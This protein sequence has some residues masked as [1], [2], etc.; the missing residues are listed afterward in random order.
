MCTYLVQVDIADLIIM[1][2]IMLLTSSHHAA[3]IILCVIMLL[4]LA[5]GFRSDV[6]PLDLQMADGEELQDVTGSIHV[7]NFSDKIWCLQ[8]SIAS[9]FS[10]GGPPTDLV[11]GNGESRILRNFS[12]RVVRR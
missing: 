4:S 1:P 8:K 11:A 10:R 2:S 12:T 6:L 5:F 3:D 9:R 7:E